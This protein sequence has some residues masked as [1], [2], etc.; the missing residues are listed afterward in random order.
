VRPSVGT[1]ATAF[2]WTSGATRPTFTNLGLFLNDRVRDS[3]KSTLNIG[4][5]H[6]VNHGIVRAVGDEGDVINFNGPATFHPGTRFEGSGAAVRVLHNATFIGSF[7]SEPATLLL[8]DGRFT[9]VDARI[10][11][12]VFW[13]G[14]TLAET[15][16]NGGHLLLL[17]RTGGPLK[18]IEGNLVNEGLISWS[19][20]ESDALVLGRAT[21]TT[22]LNRG[23]F[24]STAD[25]GTTNDIRPELGAVSTFLN[26]G[27]FTHA[28]RGQT[29]V[30]VRFE[31]PGKVEVFDGTLRFDNELKQTGLITG[32]RDAVL[33]VPGGTVNLGTIAGFRLVNLRTSGEG[34]LIN[35]GHV[36][37]GASPGTLLIEGGYEHAAGGVLDIELQDSATFDRLTV[38]GNADLTGGELALH[39]FARCDLE[40]GDGI[41]F[42]DVGG[43]LTG[44]FAAVTLHGFGDGWKFGVAYDYGA[45]RVSLRVLQVGAPPP[46]SEPGA[47]LMMLLGLAA[48]VAVRG[49][50]AAT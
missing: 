37:P 6:F 32:A 10:A 28:S 46:V 5:V 47:M 19:G 20:L 29:R 15:W 17:Q 14:G 35:R 41:H 30:G 26:T 45:D 43:E 27:T 8:G 42:L 36:V 18:R 40:V 3:A 50:R 24:R 25:R 44:S 33:V 22:V 13:D 39:C 23:Q 4:D 1:V 9:G 16:S 21:P 7:L 38:D 2:K 48:V 34:A 49:R 12:A 31:N 11:G